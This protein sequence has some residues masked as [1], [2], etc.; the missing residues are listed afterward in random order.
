M[1]I[2][3]DLEPTHLSSNESIESTT[4]PL[5]REMKSTKKITTTKSASTPMGSASIVAL[6]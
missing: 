4:S 2:N 3:I 6:L 5:T 1:G